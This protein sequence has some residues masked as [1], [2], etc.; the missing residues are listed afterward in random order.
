MVKLK[1]T[2][3]I[4]LL[5]LL[6]SCNKNRNAQLPSNKVQVV[7]SVEFKLQQFNQRLILKEDSL[8]NLFVKNQSA[9]FKKSDLGIWYYT[10]G[11]KTDGKPLTEEKKV[12][13]NY[14]IYSLEYVLLES[15]RAVE[16]EFGKKMVPIGLENGI[17]MMKNSDIIR[18]L[19][20]WYLAYGAD[21][22]NDILPYSSLIFEV[23]VSE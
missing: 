7:D 23:E 6:F 2:P 11:K 22:K 5:L 4:F 9:P 15:H 17:K 21:G 12:L 1:F 3:T 18:I 10:V 19:V 14:R 16:I 8:L 13:V 20:P